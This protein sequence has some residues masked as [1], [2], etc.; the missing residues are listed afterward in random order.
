MC[1]MVVEFSAEPG[2]HDYTIL[3]LNALNLDDYDKDDPVEEA[4]EPLV[5][6]WSEANDQ[7][8]TCQT[9]LD[10]AQSRL[11]RYRMHSH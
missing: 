7:V 2:M 8:S 5:L 6:D 11:L 10:T 4:E 9:E 1:T 3:M